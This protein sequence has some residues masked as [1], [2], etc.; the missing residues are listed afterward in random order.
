MEAV[1]Q[2]GADILIMKDYIEQRAVDLQSAIVVNETQLPEPV[3]E[4]TNS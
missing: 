3:H 4:K 2:R 1:S